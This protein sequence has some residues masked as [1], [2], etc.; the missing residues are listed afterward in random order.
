MRLPRQRKLFGIVVRPDLEER[1]Q[2]LSEDSRFDLAGSCAKDPFGRGRRRGSFGRW[3]YPV[4]LP[5]GRRMTLFRTL[6]SNV[7]VNDCAYCPLRLDQDPPRTSLS[8]EE[9]ARAFMAYLR[10]GLVQGLFLS[11]GVIRD[12]DTTMELLL[13]V[14]RFLREKE[15]FRGYVHLKVIPGASEAAVGEAATLADALS[16]NLEAPQK[17]YFA[18]LS[19][20]KRF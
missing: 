8:P 18:R 14:V 6:L 17:G 10:R 13:R 11:S 4:V 7:C 20:R 1:L 9:L 2:I 5:S 15:G 3:V 19:R 12:P 16:L